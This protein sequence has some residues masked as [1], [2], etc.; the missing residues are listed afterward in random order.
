MHHI[1]LAEP[2]NASATV[3]QHKQAREATGPQA[4]GLA[5]LGNLSGG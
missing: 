2:L 3:L 4:G 1:L 5:V